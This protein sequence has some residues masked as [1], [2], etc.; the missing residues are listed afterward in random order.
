MA[1]IATKKNSDNDTKALEQAE[2]VATKV[3]S[4]K[5]TNS[6]LTNSKPI[7]SKVIVKADFF[8]SQ[9]LAFKNIFFL[10]Y[11]K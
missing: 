9:S 3:S 2:K 6:K 4:T 10:S 1:K 7:T 5:L 8:I 11:K